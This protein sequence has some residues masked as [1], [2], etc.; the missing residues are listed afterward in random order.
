MLGWR[1]DV[2]D[3]GM[4]DQDDAI[5]EIRDLLAQVLRLVE[6]LP[7]AMAFA[8]AGGRI[9]GNVW[10]PQI[11]PPYGHEDMNR[12]I[13]WLVDDIAEAKATG[14]ATPLSSTSAETTE[15]SALALIETA[16][17]DLREHA[18]GLADVLDAA[19]VLETAAFVEPD[20][21]GHVP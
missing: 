3:A 4:A 12:W 5:D 6:A 16:R 15:V 19:I 18:P 9:G 7:E 17:A 8:A 2:G 1:H 20:D 14:E 11:S 10:Q 13:R 21:F